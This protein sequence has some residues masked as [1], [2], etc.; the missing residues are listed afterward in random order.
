M[1]IT[2]PRNVISKQD[3]YMY[4]AYMTAMRSKDPSTQV[5]AIIVSKD[6]QP[7]SSGYNGIPKQIKDDLIDW[8][9][10]NKYSFVHHAEDNAIWHAKGKDLTGS[11]MF[12]TMFPCKSCMLDIVRSGIYNVYYSGFGSKLLDESEIE[13]SKLIA[14]LGNIELIQYNQNFDEIIQYFNK[15]KGT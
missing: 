11:S 2:P 13:K 12:V 10:P 7:I 4:L 15:F 9:R 14:K 6:N 8:S 3:Y 5:G 1:N